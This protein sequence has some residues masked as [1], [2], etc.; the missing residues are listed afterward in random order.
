MTSRS[1]RLNAVVA[2]LLSAPA[3]A[4]ADMA[5]PERT[6]LPLESFNR[7]AP[8]TALDIVQQIPGISVAEDEDGA[9]GF[10]QASG[11]VLIDGQ[12]VSG[13]SNGARSALGRIPV[14]RVLRI[15][16]ADAS[17]FGLSGVTGQVVNVVTTGQGGTSGTWKMEARWRDDFKPSLGVANLSLS[18]GKGAVSWTLQA[19]NSPMRR[20]N[21]GFRSVFDGTGA[22]T[23]LR[24]EKF[25]FYV[26]NTSLS[27]SVGFKPASGLVG[28][29]NGNFTRYKETVRDRA[30]VYPVAGPEGRRVFQGVEDG[31]KSEIGADLEFGAGPG[32]LKL[33][34]LVRH[35]H[36]PVEDTFLR[37]GLDGSNLFQSDFRQTTDEG[38][39]ILR[40]EY[41]LKPAPGREWQASAESAFN[42]LEA[43]TFLAEGFGGGALI[44]V[45]LNTSNVRVEERRFEAMLTHTRALSPR[46]TLQ[47][48]IGAEQSELSQS[49]DTAAV[50]EFVRPKGYGSLSWTASDDLKLVTRLERKVGQLDFFD[51]VSSVDL[52]LDQGNAGNPEIV[53]EQAW[54]LSLQAEK[55]FAAWGA[56]TAKITFE[57]IE[58]IVDRVPIGAGDGPGNIASA[59]A[60]T[61]ELDATLKF[62][63]IGWRG[64]QLTTKAVFADSKLED[65]FTG[66]RRAISDDL[67]YKVN[68][69]F[70]HDIPKTPFAWGLAYER[71]QETD[72]LT[73]TERRGVSEPPGLADIFIEHKDLFGLKGKFTVR[74]ML[75]LTDEYERQVFSPDRSGFLV[76]DERAERHRGLI[77]MVTLNGTF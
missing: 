60:V 64:A 76:R 40:S 1:L 36:N 15:E 9:R 46:L 2:A 75:D 27:G 11:N 45:V 73:R 18:G 47:A 13:K 32:R 66:E 10:G 50:Q 72:E 24:Q 44:P 65:P 34:S 25:T 16:V 51:F 3:A 74:N 23:E 4:I 38:E 57:Q 67:A 54:A 22:L 8:R 28:N 39:Y 29:L 33:I 55:S 17:A 26:D 69:T 70:R 20:G 61:V 53:P 43:D 21:Q 35:K 77:F 6:V 19:D 71:V 58:D 63:P 41:S 52:D 49:G 30:Q 48:A 14:A 59:D 31:W 62:E 5:A 42:F 68:L 7:F 56:A 12:R 37:G